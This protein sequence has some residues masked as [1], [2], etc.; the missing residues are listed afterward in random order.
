MRWGLQEQEGKRENSQ[1]S[2]VA[3]TPGWEHT[4]GAP[5]LGVL[6]G[7][8]W[9]AKEGPSRKKNAASVCTLESGMTSPHYHCK[10]TSSFHRAGARSQRPFSSCI[11]LV[12]S[13]NGAQEI[14]SVV[15]QPGPHSRGYKGK[16]K[17]ARCFFRTNS[18]NNR[19]NDRR[20]F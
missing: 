19:K 12:C 11:I 10:T 17:Q 6:S 4:S 20:Q 5:W 16:W 2:G 14:Q 7:L 13:V 1:R 9:L 15:S 8:N 3:N 18:L